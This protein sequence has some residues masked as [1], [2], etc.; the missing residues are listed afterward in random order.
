MECPILYAELRK[1]V[2]DPAAPPLPD[3]TDKPACRLFDKTTA[4]TF[5]SLTAKRFHP[6]GPKA[7]LDSLTS[8]QIAAWQAATDP[9]AKAIMLYVTAGVDLE[10]EPGTQGRKRLNALALVPAFT[11]SV[12]AVKAAAD[13]P[14]PK[15]QKLGCE[16]EANAGDVAWTRKQIAK[17]KARG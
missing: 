17:E 14:Y 9:D 7:F 2:T 3:P 8:A 11:A 12:D 5:N 1:H 16:R 13:E 6:L 4:A 15:W 10:V